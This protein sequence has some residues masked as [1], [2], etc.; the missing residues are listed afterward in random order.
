MSR[1]GL[2]IVIV[3]T[4]LGER[5]SQAQPEPKRP[6]SLF[7]FKKKQNQYYDIPAQSNQHRKRRVALLR[8]VHACILQ[9]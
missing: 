6:S 2:W 8:G 9:A 7:F 1:P 5:G 3:V 4:I